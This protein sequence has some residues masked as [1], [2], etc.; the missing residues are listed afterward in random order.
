MPQ[1]DIYVVRKTKR[2]VI[3]II[4]AWAALENMVAL[5]HADR[6]G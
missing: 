1:R 2:E 6:Q 5:D 4:T 3:V